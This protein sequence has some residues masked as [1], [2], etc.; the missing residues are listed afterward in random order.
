MAFSF[1]IRFHLPEHQRLSLKVPASPIDTR[2]SPSALTLAAGVPGKNIDECDRLT[3]RGDGYVTENDALEGG[4]RL[5]DVLTIALAH[6][7]LGADFGDRA[8][9]GWVTPYGLELLSQERGQR[10][11]ND[12]HGVMTFESDPQPRFASVHADAI[13]GVGE[14]KVRSAIAFAFDKARALNEQERLAFDLYSSSFF[15]AS[16]DARLVMLVTAIET[17]IHRGPR[18]VEAQAHVNQ[19]VESVKASSL[20]SAER[21]AILGALKDLLVESIGQAARRLARSLIGRTYL[22]LEPEQFAT[23]AYSL[24]SD[25]VHGR[26]P[27]PT[28]EDVSA[29]RPPLEAFVGDLLAGAPT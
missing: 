20:A 14:A 18:S 5:R 16:P 27:R 7:H 25:L 1:R 9:K 15:Q 6:L 11:L 12:V 4:E 28:R 19:F 3:L 13:V 17:L 24:R 8:A 29:M 21:D 23:K 2:G 22:E 10:V 26:F